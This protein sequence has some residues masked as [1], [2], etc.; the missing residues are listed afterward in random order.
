MSST[1]GTA[2]PVAHSASSGSQVSAYGSTKRDR[3]CSAG[4]RL[5]T[6]HQPA[7]RKIRPSATRATRTASA[8]GFAGRPKDKKAPARSVRR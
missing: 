3:A 7:M 6:F 4:P 1:N 5:N 2:V 8:R